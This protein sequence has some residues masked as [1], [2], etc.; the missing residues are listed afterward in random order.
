MSITR[1]E[2]QSASWTGPTKLELMPQPEIWKEF[3]APEC[4]LNLLRQKPKL[5]QERSD[6]RLTGIIRIRPFPLL[7]GLLSAPGNSTLAPL[8]TFRNSTMPDRFT[9]VVAEWTS[10]FHGSG[11]LASRSSTLRWAR[12]RMDWSTFFV[13]SRK[14]RS[15][16]SICS[17]SL[18]LVASSIR[19]SSEQF[20][21]M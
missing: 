11:L 4:S 17:L 6:S 18:R 12:Y 15:D 21:R 7:P 5:T 20:L 13:R 1:D 9:M 16:R 8:P 19:N 2:L 10:I 3:D 14:L